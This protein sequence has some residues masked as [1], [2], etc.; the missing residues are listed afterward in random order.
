[1]MTS[2]SKADAESAL[3]EIIAN[4]TLTRP[5]DDASGM[6]KRQH[7]AACAIT[8][9]AT[10]GPQGMPYLVWIEKSTERAVDIADALIE[11]LNATDTTDQ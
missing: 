5:H 7:F 10:D 3:A 9:L 2:L 11:A 1:M 4:R 6:S 8:G